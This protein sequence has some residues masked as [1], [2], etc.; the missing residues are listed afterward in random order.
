M[1]PPPSTRTVDPVAQVVVI[2]KRTALASLSLDRKS[3]CFWQRQAF[4]FAFG[5]QPIIKLIAWE[6][7]TLKID[8]I[9]PQPDFFVTGFVDYGGILWVRLI[10]AYANLQNLISL[11]FQFHTL[12]PFLS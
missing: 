1:T 12:S 2:K 11:I 10:R 7:A 6:A 4:E 3:V 9:G 8:F 5:L